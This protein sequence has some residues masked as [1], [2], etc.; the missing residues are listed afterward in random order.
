MTLRTTREEDIKME[1]TPKSNFE[2]FRCAIRYDV[3]PRNL[4]SAGYV[5]SDEILALSVCPCSRCE[6][7]DRCYD[8]II[9]VNKLQLDSP[10]QTEHLIRFV[11]HMYKQQ[12]FDT[13]ACVKRLRGESTKC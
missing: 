8:I 2:I 11:Y 3:R 7:K 13:N 6:A 10:I 5:E 4:G 12:Y 9:F 1:I